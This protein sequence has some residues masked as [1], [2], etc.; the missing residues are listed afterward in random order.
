MRESTALPN[1]IIEE[2]SSNNSIED[3][4]KNNI[5]TKLMNCSSIKAENSKRFNSKD[6]K[7]QK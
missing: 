7:F 5:E 6:N 3:Q 2:K 4:V 1:I